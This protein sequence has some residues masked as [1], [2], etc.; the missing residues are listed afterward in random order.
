MALTFV[1]T[2]AMKAENPNSFPRTHWSRLAEVKGDSSAERREA[3]NYLAEH[4]WKPLF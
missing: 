3:L 1:A 2:F 4:Y